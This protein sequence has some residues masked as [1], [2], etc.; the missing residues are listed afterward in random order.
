MTT[1]F[2][3]ILLVVSSQS[4]LTA[5]TIPTEA[6]LSCIESLEFP[7]GGLLSSRAGTSGTVEV[8]VE[9]G[10]NGK[11][12]IRLT[13][14]NQLLKSEVN[15][16]MALSRFA[17]RCEGRIVRLSFKFVLHD[18]PADNLMPPAVR[19]LPPNRFE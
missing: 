2:V 10:K 9:I 11:P 14:D 19:F 1:G 15:V 17:V 16:A 3:T 7:T 6:D 4:V 8:A 12:Q 13:G 18:P 5:Q